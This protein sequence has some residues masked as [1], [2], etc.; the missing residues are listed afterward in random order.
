M[1]VEGKNLTATLR[2]QSHRFMFIFCNF[3]NRGVTSHSK[4]KTLKYFR[5]KSSALA[6]NTIH[7]RKKPL[8]TNKELKYC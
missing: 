1:I 5:L 8:W 7:E 2:N 4:I 3:I 6:R